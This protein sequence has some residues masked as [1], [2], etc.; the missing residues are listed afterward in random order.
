LRVVAEAEGPVGPRDV[1]Q[2]LGLPNSTAYRSLVTLLEAGF[3]ARHQES[4]A[5][6]LGERAENL[7][8]SFFLRFP[9]RQVCLPF[10]QQLSFITGETVHLSV[11]V[12]WYDVVIASVTGQHHVP[13]NALLG[14]V[15]FLDR[16]MAGLAML[17]IMP[18]GSVDRFRAWRQEKMGQM[19]GEAAAA[20]ERALPQLEERLEA[21]R[22]T[23]Y[24]VDHQRFGDYSPIAFSLRG[25]SSVVAAITINGAAVG[26]DTAAGELHRWQAAIAEIEKL[27]GQDPERFADPF[28]AAGRDSI[29]LNVD[30]P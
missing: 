2:K 16:T 28:R 30:G 23:G 1:G 6:V 12:G 11:P 21:I 14:T 19:P 25:P 9:L 3:I 15:A 18:A 5:Y 10:L 26:R 29:A 17:A 8:R 4:T 13:D 22:P 27:I 7:R 20:T 24:A